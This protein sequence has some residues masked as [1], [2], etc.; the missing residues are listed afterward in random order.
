MKRKVTVKGIK[1]KNRFYM[2]KELRK[3]IDKM[4]YVEET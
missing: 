4:V 2:H 3:Y 1:I